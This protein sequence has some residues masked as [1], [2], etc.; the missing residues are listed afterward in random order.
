MKYQGELSKPGISYQINQGKGYLCM[1]TTKNRFDEHSI[2]FREGRWQCDP[3]TDYWVLCG[4]VQL[5]EWNE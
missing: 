3:E 2:H 5:T 1:N 4:P